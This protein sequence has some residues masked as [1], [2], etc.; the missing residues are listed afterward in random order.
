M[1]ILLRFIYRDR[2]LNPEPGFIIGGQTIS[3][4]KHAVDSM[5]MTDTEIKLHDL[6]AI[7]LKSKM[8]G[9]IITY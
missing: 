9:L 1:C 8:K 3:N 2:I 7:V 5:V 4:K 6:R